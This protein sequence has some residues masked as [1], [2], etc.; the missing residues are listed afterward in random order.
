MKAAGRRDS[1]WAIA[2]AGI[3]IVTT[4]VAGCGQASGSSQPSAISRASTPALWSHLDPGV[5]TSAGFS[6]VGNQYVFAATPYDGVFVAVGEDLQF[7]GP[8]NG[9]IWT[10]HDAATWTRLGVA[11]NGLADAEVDL[12]ATDGKRLVAIGT[13]S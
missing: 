7:N 12:V 3:M 8:V 4:G 2:L 9:G 11:G 10:T 13:I 1:Y 5:P 6:G